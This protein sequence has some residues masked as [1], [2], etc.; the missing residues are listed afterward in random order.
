[1]PRRAALQRGEVIGARLRVE[2]ERRKI[3]LRELARRLGVTASL[4][5]QIETG[6]SKPSV[7]TLYGIASELGLS[8]DD[9]L[10]AVDA[11][12]RQGVRTGHQRA[13]RGGRR[14]RPLPAGTR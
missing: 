7:S 14:L 2:R 3:G 1:M 11:P 8:L 9:L 13:P 6:K 12:S 10:F 4:I 5:S